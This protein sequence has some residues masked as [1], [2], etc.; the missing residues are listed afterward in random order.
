MDID[1][2]GGRVGL[3]I[4]KIGRS[5]ALRNQP[6]VGLHHRLVEI[7]AAEIASV[8]EEEL[9]A[10]RLAGALGTAYKAIYPRKRSR[11][12]DLRHL[13]DNPLPQDIENPVF[14]GLGGLDVEQVAAV[15]GKGEG[16]VRPRQGDAGEL[17]HDVA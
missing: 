5:H 15:V 3:Y 4:N 13:A 1:V 14:Q 12:V 6:L 8:D 2:Y 9:V 17:L 16:D 11:G 7:G 10:E